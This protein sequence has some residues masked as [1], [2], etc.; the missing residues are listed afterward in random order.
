M[1]LAIQIGLGIVLG[2]AG[3]WLAG[4]FFTAAV[5]AALP[6]VKIP[7]SRPFI[8]SVAPPSNRP[9]MKT[10]A[11]PVVV[12]RELTEVNGDRVTV[13][14]RPEYRCTRDRTQIPV[15]I[16]CVNTQTQRK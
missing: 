3:C 9:L 16:T 11:A 5:V 4:I 6:P 7:A 13:L 15:A 10:P 8:T 14:T 2:V 12:S 1:K